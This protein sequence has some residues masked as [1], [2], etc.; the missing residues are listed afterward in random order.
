[1]KTTDEIIK[2]L[3]DHKCFDSFSAYVMTNPE[4]SKYDS[5]TSYINKNGNSSI[6]SNAFCS[7]Y[8]VEGRDY[9]EDISSEFSEWYK[10]STVPKFSFIPYDK[11]LT[12]FSSESEW[13]INLFSHWNHLLEKRVAV[14]II[15]VY[16]EENIIPFD[17]NKVGII[18]NKSKN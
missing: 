11:V 2:W 8:S 9:W 12:R 3:K 16:T 7:K 15:G 14:C 13:R 5:I 1:M 18:E 4:N 17:P 10:S 6:I